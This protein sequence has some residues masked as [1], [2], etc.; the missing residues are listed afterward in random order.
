MKNLMLGVCG[1]YVVVIRIAAFLCY[2]DVDNTPDVPS[3]SNH[4]DLPMSKINSHGQTD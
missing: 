1:L 2:K 4:G 3:M